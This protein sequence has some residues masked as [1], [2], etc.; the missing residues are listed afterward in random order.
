LDYKCK[1]GTYSQW[2]PPDPTTDKAETKKER[3]ENIAVKIAGEGSSNL[4]P[5][6]KKFS[7]TAVGRALIRKAL[8][9]RGI[10]PDTFA[11]MVE[12]SAQVGRGD[13]MQYN[14]KT[15]EPEP[16]SVHSQLSQAAREHVTK[17]IGRV[18]ELD[19]KNEES[20]D[21]IINVVFSEEFNQ[22][23]SGKRTVGVQIQT[24][25]ETE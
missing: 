7:K 16:V 14:T 6:E 1:T 24:S 9:D 12:I 21:K 11:E 5:A 2:T 22:D 4:T 25:S 17:E 3:A 20:G 8:E 15:G 13:C 18:H 19:R 10:T 23:G